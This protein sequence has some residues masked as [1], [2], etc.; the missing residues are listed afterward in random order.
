MNQISEGQKVQGSEAD[1]Q[2]STEISTIP[3]AS[4]E[5]LG[6]KAKDIEKSI[7][8]MLKRANGEKDETVKRDGTAEVTISRRITDSNSGE[9]NTEQD[10]VV[11][12]PK[13]IPV[14]TSCDVLV[15]G[16]GPSGLSA[17]VSAARVKGTEVVLVERFGCFGGV[18]TTVGMETLAWYRYEG[19]VDVEGIGIEF[20]NLAA[21]M[22]AT[23]KFPYNNSECLDAEYFK[24]IADHLV[25]ENNIRPFL[26]TT[27]CEVIMDGNVIK[28]AICESKSGRFA[29]LAKRVVD[30]SGDADVA[31]LSGA[32]TQ[33]LQKEAM[34]GVTTVFNVSGVDCDKFIDYTE[35]KKTTYADWIKVWGQTTDT[36]EDVLRSPVLEDEFRQAANDGLIP[37][38]SEMSQKKISIGGTWSSL[39]RET[40]EATNLNLIY[41]KNVDGTNVKDLTEAEMEGRVQ[42]LN[43]IMALKANVPGFEKCKLRNF[44]MTLG[45]RDT[46]KIVGKYFLSENDVKN[47]AR[48]EDSIGIFP[49]FIDG[50]NIVILPTSG[51]YFQVPFGCLVPADIDNL[52]VGGRIVAGD[53]ISHAAM[54]NMMACCVTGQGAGVAAA[55][56]VQLNQNI[57][58]VDILKVQEELK[59][60]GVRIE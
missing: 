37:S 14:V 19:T 38:D 45:V 4:Q 43:A 58:N 12:P 6:P 35:K 54:R 46:R 2:F 9:I 30:C 16:G 52:V 26:H 23:R 32:R 29:I 60:Q 11:E 28:G 56:S 55:I 24:V 1:K 7:D 18:I 49:E 21:K 3:P 5:G 10:F 31:H 48:F 13:R 20:E 57:H 8:R 39:A 17:A 44:G 51:R 34:M 27:V 33:K 40:G 15:V 25:K 47:E 59:R 36:K 41:M 50:Y 22:G 42:T 53:M